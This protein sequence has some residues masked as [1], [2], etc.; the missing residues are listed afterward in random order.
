ML[1]GNF[2]PFVRSMV[3]VVRRKDLNALNVSIRHSPRDQ[4]SMLPSAL[5][6]VFSFVLYCK[7]RNTQSAR[8]KAEL[9]TQELIDVALANDGRY[10]LPYRLDATHH[11][12]RQAYP[13]VREFVDLENEIDPEG[14][15]QNL[16]LQ[17]Y[18]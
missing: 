5:T 16:L 14:K 9:W 3:R 7:Q 2:V 17:K 12:F 13:E 10:Y 15:F 1:V 11:Q 4:A 18:L 8:R 6:E